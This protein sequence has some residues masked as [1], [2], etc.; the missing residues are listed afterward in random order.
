M[1][2]KADGRKAACETFNFIRTSKTQKND[3]CALKTTSE[4]LLFVQGL[5]RGGLFFH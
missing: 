1:K 3:H 2:K 4:L 5:L